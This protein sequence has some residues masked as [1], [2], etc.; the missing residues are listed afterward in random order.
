MI[1][2]WCSGTII[3]PTVG[4]GCLIPP[5]GYLWRSSGS[6]RAG[7]QQHIELAIGLQFLDASEGGEHALHGARAV[8]RV[9]DD[10]QIAALTGWFDAKEHAAPNRDTAILPPLFN[11]CQSIDK[12]TRV[13]HGTANQPNFRPSAQ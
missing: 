2:R 1:S 11:Q 6:A 13:R 8:A 4:C 5:I 10:L 9:F 12:P 3:S 7:A